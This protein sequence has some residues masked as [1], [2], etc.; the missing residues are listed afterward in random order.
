M[1]TSF[2]SHSYSLFTITVLT[3][4]LI[5]LYNKVFLVISPFPE[6]SLNDVKSQLL[7]LHLVVILFSKAKLVNCVYDRFH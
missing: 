3:K 5:L 6:V 1:C 2:I 7:Q 4:K